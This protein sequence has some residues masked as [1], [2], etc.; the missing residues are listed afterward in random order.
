MQTSNA[1]NHVHRPP[2]PVSATASSPL[3][4]LQLNKKLPL[5]L[6]QVAI[7][8]WDNSEDTSV[9]LCKILDCEIIVGRSLEPHW[10]TLNWAVCVCNREL[11]NTKTTLVSN[12]QLC[13]TVSSFQKMS[14]CIREAS[15]HK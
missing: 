4:L 5:P 11:R 14:I 9:K 8:I 15:L 3:Q 7:L 10:S 13:S 2:L 1:S 12:I 6:W